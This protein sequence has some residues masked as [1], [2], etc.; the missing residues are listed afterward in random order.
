MP[1]LF[2]LRIKNSVSKFISDRY[3]EIAIMDFLVFPTKTSD[4]S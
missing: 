2:W 4:L 3:C 1:K